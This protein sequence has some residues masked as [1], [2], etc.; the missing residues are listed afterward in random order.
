M[1][2]ETVEFE[3]KFEVELGRGMDVGLTWHLRWDSALYIYV[4]V[5]NVLKYIFEI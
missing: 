4:D 1:Y 3:V 5:Q 2:T